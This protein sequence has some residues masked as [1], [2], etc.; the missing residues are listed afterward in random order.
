MSIVAAHGFAIITSNYTCCFI[1]NFRFIPNALAQLIPTPL[2]ILGYLR[3]ITLFRLSNIPN[4]KRFESVV[5]A[6]MFI[7]LSITCSKMLVCCREPV[8]NLTGGQRSY[9]QCVHNPCIFQHGLS[10]SYPK[11]SAGFRRIQGYMLSKAGD[12][13]PFLRYVGI[14]I[15]PAITP[16]ISYQHINIAY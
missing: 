1:P 8:Y 16:A 3:Y 9:Q 6:G 11:P 12:I 14:Y 15:P 10:I 2:G 13:P 7:T 4:Y 5:S